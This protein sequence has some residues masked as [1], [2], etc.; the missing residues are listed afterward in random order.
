MEL[1]K[2]LGGR[3]PTAKSTQEKQY[4]L[5]KCPGCERSFEMQINN[6][7]TKQN[8]GLIVRCKSCALKDNKYSE[9][10]GQSH[11]S[12]RARW[13]LMHARCYNT[14]NK[15]YLRY[16]HIGIY[17]DKAWHKYD[18]FKAWF[19]TDET[20]ELHRKDNKGP[21][22]VDNCILLSATDHRKLHAGTL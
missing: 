17:V 22:S 12:L 3:Y 13:N 10:H 2:R 20:M 16:G 11:E 9:R 6:V 4:G 7:N 19:G 14:S 1:I 5:Y 18:N 15:S 21:Y 8:K